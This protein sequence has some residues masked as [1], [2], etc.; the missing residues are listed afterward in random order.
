MDE[1]GYAG[2]IQIEGAIPDGGEMLPS[3]RQNLA[4]LRGVFS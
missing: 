2:W 3:Y 4:F 1:I